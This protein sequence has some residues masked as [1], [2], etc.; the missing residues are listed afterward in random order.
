MKIRT[1]KV[2]RWMNDYEDDAKYNLAETWAPS[3][4]RPSGLT[5][6]GII[7]TTAI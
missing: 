3:T 5:T 2:E 4:L 7:T 6:Q 1:F